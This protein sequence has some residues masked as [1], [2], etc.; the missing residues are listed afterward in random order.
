MFIL[1]PGHVVL[2]EGHVKP[3]THG[4]PSTSL[5]ERYLKDPHY[6]DPE[7]MLELI[8]WWY[9]SRTFH[10]ERSD[11]LHKFLNFDIFRR[12]LQG[13]KLAWKFMLDMVPEHTEWFYN[14]EEWATDFECLVEV[15]R[16]AAII[17]SIDTAEY[18]SF[19]VWPDE[20]PDLLRRTLMQS[21]CLFMK[22]VDAGHKVGLRIIGD[23]SRAIGRKGLAE[24]C[25]RDMWATHL[26]RLRLRLRLSLGLVSE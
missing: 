7:T 24:P 26:P 3:G 14:A 1:P 23:I 19:G 4:K 15:K 8:A 21:R 2:D 17:C 5:F 11:I 13:R 20:M 18:N 6:V 16:G 22:L 9:E 10:F 25:R 12:H